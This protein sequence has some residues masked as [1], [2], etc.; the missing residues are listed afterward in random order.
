MSRVHT[1][2]TLPNMLFELNVPL[3]LQSN[4]LSQENF[5]N[6]T[7][8]PK[9]THI[10]RSRETYFLSNAVGFMSLIFCFVSGKKMRHFS[11]SGGKFL[12]VSEEIFIIICLYFVKQNSSIFSSLS[13]YFCELCSFSFYHSHQQHEKKKKKIEKKEKEKKF[14]YL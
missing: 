13:S 11:L 9:K 2:M 14:F 6:L 10:F 12:R 5:L 1:N 8:L 7:C 3:M 4:K